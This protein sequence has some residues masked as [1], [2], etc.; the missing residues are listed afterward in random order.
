[1]SSK[2]RRKLRRRWPIP[3]PESCSTCPPLIPDLQERDS[4]ALSCE[5]EHRYALRFRAR[6][7]HLLSLR[8]PTP[9]QA[10][11]RREIHQYMVLGEIPF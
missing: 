7:N 11:A 5:A 8:N 6:R 2:D 4:W 9:K 10:Q 3:V 1:M